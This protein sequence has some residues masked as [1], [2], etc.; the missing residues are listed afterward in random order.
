MGIKRV[1]SSQCAILCI[2]VFAIGFFLLFNKDRLFPCS[3]PL[4]LAEYLWAGALLSCQVLCTLVRLFI[5]LNVLCNL[6]LILDHGRCK[7]LFRF[8]F[9]FETM[10]ALFFTSVL[11]IDFFAYLLSFSDIKFSGRKPS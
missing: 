3:K 6:K 1:V 5:S 10:L 8:Y 11:A 2:D 7:R 4:Y 9:F